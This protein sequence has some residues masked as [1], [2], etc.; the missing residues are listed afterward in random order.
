MPKAGEK[1]RKRKRH[2]T[3]VHYIFYSTRNASEMLLDLPG[4]TYPGIR[5]SNSSAFFFLLFSG[6]EKVCSASLPCECSASRVE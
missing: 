5:P 1:E 2:K 6:P 4:K 3:A